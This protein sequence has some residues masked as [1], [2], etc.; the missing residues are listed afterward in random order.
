MLDMV[1]ILVHD[2][3]IGHAFGSFMSQPRA[4]TRSVVAAAIGLF[5]R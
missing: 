5:D 3:G 1:R 4:M 2:L